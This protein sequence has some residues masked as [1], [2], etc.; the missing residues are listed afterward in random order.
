MN[1]AHDMGGVMGFGPVTPEKNEPVFHG[2]WEERVLAMTLA[3]APAAGWNIDQSRFA[4][5]N[6][7][8]Q[9]YLSRSYYEIWFG[10]LTRLLAERGMVMPDELAA[11]KALHPAKPAQRVLAAEDT[12]AFVAAGRSAERP[13]AAPARFKVGD[14][15]RT[16]N[17]HPVGHT[18]LPRY[19]RGHVGVVTHLHGGHV[20]PDTNARGE[21]EA[22]EWLYTVRFA[23]RDLWGEAADPTVSVSVDAWDSY[24]EATS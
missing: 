4:R 15:V 22:P 21:G 2:L 17:I 8:P 5:E 18:R 20:Y 12:W 11:G 16:K 23:A 6:I 1:G 3:M 13:M 14:H 9:T 19:V 10:G 24:L 7:P